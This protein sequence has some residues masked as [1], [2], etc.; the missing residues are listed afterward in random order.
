M[1]V[2]RVLEV[3]HLSRSYGALSA[4]RALSFGVSRGEILGLLGVNGAG[5]STTMDMLCGVLAPSAGRVSI[6]G[7][8][9]AARPREARRLIGY[10]PEHPPLYPELTVS[11]Y[12]HFCARLRGLAGASGPAVDQALQRC[13]LGGV[14]ER[15]LGNLSKGF[16]QRVGLAQAL[17]HDPLLL[18]LDE[19]SAGLDPLQ[20]REFRALVR[21]LAAER[22][23]IMSTHT[24]P[25]VT[26]LCSRVLILVEGQVVH[27]SSLDA[28]TAGTRRL[29]LRC[30]SPP[31]TADLLALPG[32]GAAEAENDGAICLHVTGETDPAPAIATLVVERGWGLLELAPE[33]SS[34]ERAFVE[35]TCRQPGQTLARSGAAP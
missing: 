14:G 30:Q 31:H 13:N 1:P 11:E 21:E 24:L 18:V 25:E 9:L 33:Q 4:V 26:A 27:E 28:L 12:L 2:E 19:P 29:R 32:I 7:I 16:Q 20:L 34:L 35:V 22:A 17:L 23:V 15:L 6:G 10:L 3:E 8:D 5:K